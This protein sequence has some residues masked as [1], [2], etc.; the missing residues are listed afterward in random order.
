MRL[1]NRMAVFRQLWPHG[2][3]HGVLH[4]ARGQVTKRKMDICNQTIEAL[5]QEH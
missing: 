3:I 5:Y 2:V 4:K 1:L